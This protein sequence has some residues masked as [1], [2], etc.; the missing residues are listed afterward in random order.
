MKEDDSNSEI[1]SLSE[2]TKADYMDAFN[3]IK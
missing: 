2:E 1:T 3:M